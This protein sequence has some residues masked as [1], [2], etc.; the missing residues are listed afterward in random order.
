MKSDRTY[1]QHILDAIE[2]VEN[3][4]RGATKKRFLDDGMMHDSVYFQIQIIGE[5]S[6]NLSEDFLEKHPDIPWS[7]I[8]GMRNRIVHAYFQIDIEVA[9]DIVKKDIPILK[10]QIQKMLKQP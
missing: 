5:A 7:Q 3:Y 1:L 10:K 8:I 6:N 9:W 2:N 4:T